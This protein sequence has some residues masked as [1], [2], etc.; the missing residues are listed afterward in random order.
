MRQTKVPRPFHPP[1]GRVLRGPVPGRFEAFYRESLRYR[2]GERIRSADLAQRYAAWAERNQ[3]GSLHFRDICQAMRN[4]GH[5]H[6]H[7]DGATYCD[8]QFADQLPWLADNYPGSPK[9]SAD[10][11]AALVQWIDHVASELAAVREMAAGFTMD[12]RISR[13]G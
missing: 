3:A 2:V 9:S 12:E 7:S 5:R 6:L 11:A 8:V 1:E 4:I 13:H 10:A